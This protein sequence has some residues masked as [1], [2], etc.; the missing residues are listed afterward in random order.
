[1]SIYGCSLVTVGI[2]PAESYLDKL[3]GMRSYCK[4][5]QDGH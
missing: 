2:L 1:M 5:F 4:N 3:F